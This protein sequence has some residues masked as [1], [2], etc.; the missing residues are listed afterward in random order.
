LLKRVP[1][2]VDPRVGCWVPYLGKIAGQRVLLQRNEAVRRLVG[3]PAYPVCATFRVTFSPIDADGLANN[4]GPALDQLQLWLH[5]AVCF[6][7]SGVHAATITTAGTRLFVFYCRDMQV[8]QSIHVPFDAER[9]S[10]RCER[11][12]EWTFFKAIA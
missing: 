4:E 6:G 8:P 9:L 12:E 1:A 11:D 5:G 10:V 3:D 2:D 7:G